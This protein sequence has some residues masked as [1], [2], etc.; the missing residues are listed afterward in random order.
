MPDQPIDLTPRPAVLG[1]FAHPDDETLAAGGML[2]TLAPHADVHIVTATR[3]EMGERVGPAGQRQEPGPDLPAVRSREVQR[4]A[5]ALGA[6]SHEFL[7]G[8]DHR[9][10]DSGMAWEDERRIRA[11]P[12]PAAPAGAFSQIDLDDP[13]E[14]LAAHIRRLRPALVLTEEPAGG[15]GH[16]DHVRCHEVTM[17]AVEL[18]ATTWRVP[19]VAFVVQDETRTRAAMGELAGLAQVPSEDAYGLAFHKPDPGGDVHSGVHPAPDV[20]VDTSAVTDHIAAAMR[21]HA[22]QVHGVGEYSGADLAGWYALTNNDLKPIL[23]HAGLVLAPGWGQVAGLEEFLRNLGVGLAPT[24]GGRGGGAYPAFLSGFAVLSG[25]VVGIVGSFTHRAS[26]WALL[27]AVLAVFAGG[28]MTRSL[29]TRRTGLLYA[30]G[31]I[32]AGLLVTT[33]RPGGDVVIVEDAYGLGWLA[34]IFLAAFLGA[35]LGGAFA[36]PASGSSRA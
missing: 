34:G 30:A 10:T 35:L 17:R 26:L 5:A 20:V 28:V 36:R 7:D 2:A 9:F 16:P 31:V 24:P 23:T 6:V 13:A 25:L 8:G 3:G 21:E 14:A 12:D 27:V 33:L 11:V 4:A 15:Y 29:G 1:F 22:T 32:G 18:A 19:F